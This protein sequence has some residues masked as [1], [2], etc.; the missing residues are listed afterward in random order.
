M[1]RL[2]TYKNQLWGV[3]LLLLVMIVLFVSMPGTGL[4]IK[5]LFAVVTVGLYAVATLNITRSLKKLHRTLQE[6]LACQQFANDSDLEAL[7]RRQ[8]ESGLLAAD[9]LEI[10]RSFKES[11]HWY[12][13]ILDAIPFP[14]SVTDIDMNWTF[15]NRPVEMFL[16]VTREQVMGKQCNNWNAHICNTENCGIARLQNR[17]RGGGSGYYQ[18][19]LRQ[20]L[21]G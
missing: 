21:S 8:D 15:I 2:L 5:T 13:E 20:P 17:A 11:V 16:N 4:V 3:F 7:A 12:V 14:L 19:G 6:G 9:T 18:D 1:S 10:I